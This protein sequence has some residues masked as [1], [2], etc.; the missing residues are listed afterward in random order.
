MGSS[1]GIDAMALEPAFGAGVINVGGGSM[2]NLMLSLGMDLPDDPVPGLSELGLYEMGMGAVVPTMADRA[3][4]LNWADNLVLDPIEPHRTSPISVLYQMAAYDELVP[5][6]TFAETSLI[7][8]IPGVSPAPRPVEGLA[9]VPTPVEGNMDG[10][11]AALF[12][13]G[14]PAE[15]QFLLTCDDPM[16]MY[17]G[18]LQLAVFVSTYLEG[19]TPVVIDPFDASQVSTYA[20]LWEPP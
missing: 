13:Y 20:P 6:E 3:D 1:M 7:M 8:G 4:P 12:E 9:E 11:T 17:A 14:R 2:L 18:Q 5:Y 19:G 10:T 16:V 15:H